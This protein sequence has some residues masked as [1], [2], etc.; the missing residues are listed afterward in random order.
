M[1]E[2]RNILI[3]RFFSN[4]SRL[5]DYTEKLFAMMEIIYARRTVE[6]EREQM[7]E[8]Q[9]YLGKLQKQWNGLVVRVI[10]TNHEGW[11]QIKVDRAMNRLQDAMDEIT[12]LMDEWD[13]GLPQNCLSELWKQCLRIY[14]EVTPSQGDWTKS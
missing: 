11:A 6:L 10:G 2:E 12:H 8:F 1:G 3:E 14:L 7:E 9:G 5:R 4:A 13:E